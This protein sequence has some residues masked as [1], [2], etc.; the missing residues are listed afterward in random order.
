VP[1]TIPKKGVKLCMSAVDA[2]GNKS[3]TPC[4]ALKIGK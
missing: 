2:A 1:K 4:V 3:A